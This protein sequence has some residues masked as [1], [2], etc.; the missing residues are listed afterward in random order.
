MET[1]Q[2]SWGSEARAGLGGVNVF[3]KHYKVPFA[4]K[5][6]TRTT[7]WDDVRSMPVCGVDAAEN[8]KGSFESKTFGDG[9]RSRSWTAV[10]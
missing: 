5:V 6:M 3:I 1:T 4:W 7:W 10:P 8:Q 2:A 9:T